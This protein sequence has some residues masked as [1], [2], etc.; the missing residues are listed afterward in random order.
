MN[1]KR[2]GLQVLNS[3]SMVYTL[4]GV[5]HRTDLTGE[6]LLGLLC[7]SRGM[8][9]MMSHARTVHIQR[10]CSIS[11]KICMTKTIYVDETM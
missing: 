11:F 8:L 4:H 5:E 1:Y 7:S 6:H 3:Q 9:L 2:P 10:Q